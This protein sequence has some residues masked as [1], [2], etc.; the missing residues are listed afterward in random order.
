MTSTTLCAVPYEVTDIDGQVIFEERS[1]F[2]GTHCRFAFEWCR[3][4]WYLVDYDSG[5]GQ[6]YA[7]H[8]AA[9]IEW[10][11]NNYTVTYTEGRGVATPNVKGGQLM[12]NRGGLYMDGSGNTLHGDG[13]G[14]DAPA[15]PD[16]P[17]DAVSQQIEEFVRHIDTRVNPARRAKGLREISEDEARE[18]A[19]ILADFLRKWERGSS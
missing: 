18:C 15:Q 16:K 17:A 8:M 14:V 9:A 3:Y 5:T 13:R 7:P 1:G 2:A 10:I 12:S 4:G 11:K 6:V 19:G